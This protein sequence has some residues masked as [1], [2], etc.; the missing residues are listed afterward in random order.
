MDEEEIAQQQAAYRTGDATED[1]NDVRE[2]RKGKKR[3]QYTGA[4]Q[5][6]KSPILLA[7]WSTNGTIDSGQAKRKEASKRYPE[8]GLL[9]ICHQ[10]T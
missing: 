10:P 8:K 7:R 5:E 2:Q 4:D 1:A 3:K 9:R 6:V